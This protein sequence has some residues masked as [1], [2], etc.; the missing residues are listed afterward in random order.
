MKYPMPALQPMFGPEPESFEIVAQSPGLAAG[1]MDIVIC[2]PTFRRPQMLEQTLLSLAVQEGVGNFAVLVTENDGARREGARQ[3][4]AMLAEN[5][6]CGMVI[7]ESAQGNCNAYNAAWRCALT[8]FPHTR[9]ICGI[10]DDEIASPNWLAELVKGAKTGAGIVG[11]PVMPQFEDPRGERYRGHPVFRSHYS[12][13]GPVPMIY[14]SANYLI[15]REVIEASPWPFLDP[16]F[17]FMGG[18]DTDF[19]TRAKLRG[20]TFHWRQEAEMRETM[21]ARRSEASWIAARGY[22]NGMISALIEKKND[23]GKTGH[24]RR[25][26]R[27]LALLAAAPFRSLILA[28]KERSVTVGLYHCQVAAG[29]IMAEFGLA[30]EQYRAPE[31]N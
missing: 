20:T 15:R 11:G 12:A 6:L 14:S 2:L 10:D 27:S 23:P 4:A 25:L 22:R 13:S 17:N 19:F 29:R 26:A 5:L 28:L 7:V 18:G 8:R 3:A 1:D 21:P 9:F 31:T 16:C 24:L 30:I